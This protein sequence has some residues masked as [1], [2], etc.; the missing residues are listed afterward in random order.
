[1]GAEID[2]DDVGAHGLGGIARERDGACPADLGPVHEVGDEGDDPHARHGGTTGNSYHHPVALV[3]FVLFLT[4]PIAEL[5]VVVA[6]GERIGILDTLALMVLISAAGALLAKRQGL[7]VLQTIRDRLDRGEVPGTE[8]ID[9]LL[10]LV[11]AVLMLTP[12]FLTDA[13]ALLLLVPFVRAGIRRLLRASFERRVRVV[14][15]GDYRGGVID[16]EP[17]ERGP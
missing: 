8:L 14:R 11:A 5:A 7:R 6:V 1:M 17:E 13:L 10:V 12:G 4:V 3:L 2:D 9:G 15:S 16:V